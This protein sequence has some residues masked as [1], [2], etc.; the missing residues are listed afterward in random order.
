MESKKTIHCYFRVSTEIQAEVGSSLKNQSQQATNIGRRRNI[1][2]VKINEGPQSSQEHISRR[3]QFARLLKEIEKGNVKH[4]WVERIDRLYRNYMQQMWFAHDF[5]DMKGGTIYTGQN[6]E[7]VKF[8]TV[9]DRMMFKYIALHSESEN[10]LRSERSRHGKLYLL[11]NVA[12]QKP[13]Y[14]G[15]TPTYGYINKKKEWCIDKTESKVVKKIF[16]DYVKGKT[17]INIKKDLDSSGIKPRR[18]KYWNLETIRQ[19]LHNESYTGL[20]EWREFKRNP[21][22][23]SEK[24]LVATRHYKIPKIISTSL[25]RK[26]GRL[27]E[28]T[29]KNPSANANKK[30][31]SV[32][33]GIMKC[34]CGQSIGSTVKNYTRKNTSYQTKLYYCVSR[35]RL[36]KKT[37]IE[38]QCTNQRALNMEKADAVILEKIKEVYQ[39]SNVLKD[40]FKKSTME[41]KKKT[42]AQIKKDTEVLDSKITNLQ[43]E[44]DN[45]STSSVE[46]EY[47]RIKGDLPEQIANGVIKKIQKDIDDMNKQIS[48][49]QDD[50]DR[51]D[52]HGE[53]LDWVKR[54]STSLDKKLST[55]SKRNEFVKGLV[56]RIVVK[57]TRG[58]NRDKKE[59]QVGHQI[60][61]Y[62]KMK[63]VND[64]MVYNNPK[65]KSAGY[66]IIEG[67][68]RIRI[69]VNSVSPKYSESVV[70]QG[71]KK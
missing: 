28:L 24:I 41:L 46:T 13:V 36:W 69:K 67:K 2:V 1:K 56:D 12:S 44:V 35:E 19:M 16:N 33:D 47:R 37:E 66:S 21:N 6:C 54:Y 64:Q 57:D 68:K 32:L 17:I 11:E 60:D 4:I 22:D 7:P 20:K 18:A 59:V 14:L 25:F 42:P 3:P 45:L 43:L 52:V 48:K 23:K 51:I 71:K 53:W 27:M 40:T 49:Y 70:K 9:Q 65:K 50:I 26:A 30:F 31:V 62:F 58:L 55:P 39:N 15:G 61:I 38:N 8:E 63:V 10:E 5:I 29:H 34:E